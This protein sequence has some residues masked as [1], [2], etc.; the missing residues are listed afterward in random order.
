[1]WDAILLSLKLAA[2]STVLLLILSTILCL[3]LPKKGVFRG[4]INAFLFLPLVL[5]PTVIGF[6]LLLLFSPSMLPFNL[7][8]TFEGLVIGSVIYSLPFVYQPIQNSIN[9]ISL[10][11]QELAATMGAG[12]VDRF[13]SVTL[14]LARDGFI[15]AAILGFAHTIGEFGVVLMIGGNIPG[16]T[17]VLSVL[18]Y[19]YVEMGDYDSAHRLS[20]VL[21]AASFCLL[22]L[23][24]RF[25]GISS[26]FVSPQANVRRS[27]P[28]AGR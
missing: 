22:F 3:L 23:M 20:S 7:A 11:T 16:E 28:R 14:P 18:L 17:Q 9:S 12:P 1:M 24:Y 2:V 4:L 15:A 21:L 26:G 27:V 6:Y 8:F 25:T 13:F 10:G 19:E 5:P